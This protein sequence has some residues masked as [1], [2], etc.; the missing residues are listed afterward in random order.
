MKSTFGVL[1]FSIVL[2]LFLAGC[3][4]GNTIKFINCDFQPPYKGEV[5]HAAGFIP[6]VSIFTVW[7]DDK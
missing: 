7:N 1:I 2:V 5:I 6:G 3:W 4:I